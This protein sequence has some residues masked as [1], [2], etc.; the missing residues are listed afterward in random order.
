M[1]L[2]HK[3]IYLL[4]QT[5]RSGQL[6]AQKPHSAIKDTLFPS[7]PFAVLGIVTAFVFV[8]CHIYGHKMATVA[9]GLVSSLFCWLEGL[10]HVLPP[11]LYFRPSVPSGFASFTIGL[12]LNSFFLQAPWIHDLSGSF[13]GVLFC[14][15]TQLL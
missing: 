3:A 1:F 12:Y 8:R 14:F 10:S 11:V 7:I 15:L 2:K 13:S 4:K 5:S 9:P 6:Q